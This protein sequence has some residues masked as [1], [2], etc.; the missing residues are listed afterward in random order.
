MAQHNTKTGFD[1]IVAEDGAWTW[2]NDERAAF[3]NGILYTSYVKSDGKTAL[4]TT[5]ISTGATIGNE[6]ILSTWAQKDDH[7]N[8]S[9]LMRKDGKVM[10]FYSKHI[11]PKKNYFRTSLVDEPTQQKD[12]GKEITQITTNNS[13]HKGAT[14]NNAFQLSGE[15]GKIY[16]FMRTNNFNPNVKTYSNTGE[17]LR[18]GKDFILFKNGDGSVRPYVKYT[19]NN[20]DRIDFFFTDGHPRKADNSLYHCYYKTNEDGTQGN[21]YQTDGT[22]ITKLESIFDGKPID[23]SSVK[24]LYQFGSDG[25]KA[26][27]WTHNINYDAKGYPVVSYSKQIDIDHITYHYAK[28]DGTKWSNHLVSDAG[29]GLYKGEDD[30]TGIITIN[31]YN[32]N[33]VFMS[34]NKNPISNIEG[35]RYEIYSGITKDNGHTWKWTAITK[36]SKQDNLRPYVP[37]GITKSK[38]RVVLWF[39][40]RYTTYMNYRARIVGEFM[41]K[42]FKGDAPQYDEKVN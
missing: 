13:D 4:S 2:Y 25:T 16:N 26:R 21:I 15:N 8:A 42:K 18:K 20:I 40:G 12:W 3:K 1:F 7:N 5:D 17:P 28:W 39:H 19:S 27:A 31:P 10:A 37:K 34:S 22:F 6:I 30:Y 36:D 9:V 23:V 32:T 41:N 11:G 35:E 38:D 24:K 14:Y 29:K 33:Q